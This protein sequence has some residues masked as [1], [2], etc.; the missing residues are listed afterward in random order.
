MSFVDLIN[1]IMLFL[2]IGIQALVSDASQHVKSA[3]AS[4]IMGV[5]PILG[6]EK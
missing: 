2:C 4:V 5:S 6:K 1:P 3:L